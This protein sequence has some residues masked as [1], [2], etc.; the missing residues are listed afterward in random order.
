M[1]STKKI[2][3]KQYERKVN[4]VSVVFFLIGAFCVV[5]LFSITRITFTASDE[6]P[7][8]Q[9]GKPALIATPVTTPTTQVPP[10]TQATRIKITIGEPQDVPVATEITSVTVVTPEIAAAQIRN[11]RSLTVTGFKIGETILIASDGQKRLTFV[12]EVIGIRAVSRP[13]NAIAAERTEKEKSKTSGSY[14]GVYVQGFDGSPSVLRQNIEFRRKLSNEKTLRVSGEMFKLFAGAGRNQA[15]ARIQNLGL[16]RLSVGLD[17]RYKTIDFLDSEIRV[18]PLSFNNFTMR[19]FRLVT[20]PKP[21]NDLSKGVEVFAGLARPSLTLYDNG[22]GKLAGAIL[23][24]AGGRS[25]Q[26]RAGF[27][28]IVPQKNIRFGRGG[29]IL[30][31]EGVYAPNNKFAAEGEAAFAN[32][33]LSWRARL[34]LKFRQ[35]GAFGEIIRFDRNSPLNSIGAQPGGRKSE[36]LAFNWRP[37][38]RFN[39]S[40]NYNHIEITRLSNF[41]LADF[42]RSSF[43]VNATYRIS[44]NSRFNLRFL[45]QQI[46]T[47]VPGGLAKFRIGTRALTAGYNVR[48][49]QNWTNNFEA[50]VNFSREAEANAGLENG[51]NLNEQLR[52]SWE[53]TSVTGFFHY[54]YKTPSLTSLIVRNP[55][56]LPPALQDAF[57]LDPAQFLQVYRD[58]IAFLLNGIEL[59]Q[60]RSLDAGFRTQ[61]TVSRFTFMGEARYNAGEILS[62]NQN[63]LFIFAGLNIQLDAANSVQING[64]KSFGIS[65][66]SAVTFSYTHRFGAGSEGGFQFSKLLGFNKGHVQGRVY[67]DLNGNG[68][69]DNEPGVAGITVQLDE[70]RIVK[71]DIAGRYRFSANEGGHNI[72]LIS[73]DLGVR[74]R[75]STVT[76][77]RIAVYSG[78]IGNVSFGVSDF[79]F[80]SGRVFNDLDLTGIVPQSDLQGLKGVKVILRSGNFVVEQTTNS[81]GTYEF[82]NLRPGIYT[83]EIDSASLPANF[84]L[85]A[86]N[87]WEIRVEPL[88]GF[89]FDIPIAAQ[90]AI[91]GVIFIDKDR[92]G[93]FNPQRDEPVEGAYITANGNIAVSDA[94]GAYMI[95]NLA[96]GK[97]KLHIRSPQGA[98]S[99][100]IFVEL[101]AEPVT[102][103]AVNIVMRR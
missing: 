52:F 32:G 23:P 28:T 55:Q 51:F 82:Y 92:D 91:A 73:N 45:D 101:G 88:Q 72:A 9:P 96:A 70:N 76:R 50:R 57:I 44:Q 95:R 1:L 41:R 2:F 17:S 89:Y 4:R 21:G 49:N 38:R 7:S 103:R 65:G 71:T 35:F 77:Q 40:L 19:G 16:N 53:K 74:L 98:E 27:I 39:I 78:Q 80:I 48:F 94:N 29:T 20:T 8:A 59:P 67:Y 25:W 100:S 60:T 54:T 5:G 93:Q 14:S 97:V 85:P 81:A 90:R 68:Q 66:Q 22:S 102:R 36:G 69:D 46:E 86:Q 11:K 83:L 31:L 10:Q 37:D 64:W 43:S 42:S 58:R 61:T 13:G 33:K 30:Q 79:G 56:L 6:R 12:V 3:A 47:A 75:A 99:S 34:D 15:L 18:S 24:V 26:V 63:N 84:R 62:R 87:T